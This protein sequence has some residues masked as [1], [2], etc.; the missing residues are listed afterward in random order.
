LLFYAAFFLGDQC[1]QAV[2]GGFGVK[3]VVR[4]FL[5][6]TKSPAHRQ[7]APEERGDAHDGQK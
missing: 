6:S 7:V 1:T 5:F 4:E 2:G 3:A